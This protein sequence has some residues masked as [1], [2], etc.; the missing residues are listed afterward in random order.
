MRAHRDKALLACAGAADVWS[1]AM[2][3]AQ[4][5]C[6]EPLY[7]VTLTLTLALALTLTLGLTLTL[8]LTLTPTLTLYLTLTL[9]Q[10]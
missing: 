4:L 6:G 10:P 1:M 2:V 7:S 9:T 5:F 8:T 3:L